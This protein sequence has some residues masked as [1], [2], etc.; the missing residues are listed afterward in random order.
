MKTA[1]SLTPAASYTVSSSLKT[2]C[3]RWIETPAK[4]TKLAESG[5]LVKRPLL[6]FKD[7]VCIGFKEAEWRKALD[8]D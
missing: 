1:A 3:Q 6:V 8:L 5:M 2:K 4:A 7:R